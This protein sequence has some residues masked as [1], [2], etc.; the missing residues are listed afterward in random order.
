[1]SGRPGPARR[2]AR[3]AGISARLGLAFAFLVALVAGVG[4]I[5]LGS[6]ARLDDVT[7][8]AEE[9]F[10]R[11]KDAEQGPAMVSENARLAVWLFTSGDAAELQR[12][13]A[14]QAEASRQITELYAHFERT[15]DT[16]EELRLFEA[17]KGARASYIT[18]RAAAEKV[19]VAG[20][21]AEALAIF[22]EE[23]LPRLDDYTHAWSALLAFEGRRMDD[24]AREAASTYRR[25][26]AITLALIAVAVTFGGFVAVF[27]TARITGRIQRVAHAAERLERGELRARVDIVSDDELGALGRAWNLM[28]DAVAFREERLQR[29][30]NVAQHIQTA[31]LPQDPRIPVLELAAAMRPATEVGGDYYDVLPVR[32]GCWLAMGDVSGHGLDA[33]LIALMI[34]SA[35]AALVRADPD[36]APR[37]ILCAVNEALH[38]NLEHRLRKIG[39]A[40]MVLLRV[41]GD[42]RVTFAGAHEDMLVWRA[43][44]GRCE[45]VETPGTWLGGAARIEAATVD[46]TLQLEQGDVLVLF[47]DG[48]TEARNGDGIMFGEDRLRAELEAAA[49]D[50]VDVIRDRLLGAVAAWAVAIDDDRSV[51]VARYVGGP[52]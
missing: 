23:V 27:M 26:R 13:L 34:Q 24:A 41:R 52:S 38:E 28:A 31:I 29:E 44:A 40:T 46:S 5:G 7:R 35:V 2:R 18:Q 33:G 42:G 8:R 6:M 11:V 21:R 15:L 19:L 10:R 20:R 51:L 12:H 14:Q 48:L 16:D 39:H 17:I 45:V 36:A 1:V 9:R 43:R 32:D 22:D 50:G 25:T 4:V 37:A 3:F 49:G 47:T 30:M